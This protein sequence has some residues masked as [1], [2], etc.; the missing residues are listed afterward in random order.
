MM[1]QMSQ[2]M[3]QSQDQGGK[4][5]I[6]VS[7]QNPVTP[8][9]SPAIGPRKW[10]CG[11]NAGYR[12]EE[13]QQ[14]SMVN[15]ERHLAGPFRCRLPGSARLLHR[16]ARNWRSTPAAG[17]SRR[18]PK[19]PRTWA[20]CTR[21]SASWNGIPVLQTI[22]MGGMG[23]PGSGDA[24]AQPG[25]GGQQQQQQQ[26]AARP[27]LAERWAAPLGGKFGLGRKKQQ[28]DDQ[29][30]TGQQSQQ[31]QG[32]GNPGSLMEATTEMSGFSSDPVDESNFAVPAGSRGW[33]T[34]RSRRCRPLS[35]RLIADELSRAVRQRLGFALYQAQIGQRGPIPGGENSI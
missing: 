27:S 4:N 19:P 11:W 29:A 31:Q 17:C 16:M 28:Q 32:G 23:Q 34:A 21:K 14:G 30:S 9:K 26:P 12:P 6:Q 20:N 18:R 15:L 25:S 2:K 3:H 13:R 35:I 1:E 10:C 24:S 33:R 7:P 8:R 5:G 22:S